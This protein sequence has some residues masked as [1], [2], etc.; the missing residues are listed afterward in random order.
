M[1][2]CGLAVNYYLLLSV[3]LGTVAIAYLLFVTGCAANAEQVKKAD[4]YYQEG[5]ANLSSDR[6][7][8]FVSFQ[9]A[10][11]INPRHR[12]AHYS[13]GRLY[14]LQNR[15]KE[16]EGEFRD[17]IRIDPDHSEAH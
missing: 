2:R 1:R 5:L 14:V 8:A 10:I 7:R 11:Q 16:A 15:L 17:A 6:Q 4:G 9:K 12:D 3:L 13:L